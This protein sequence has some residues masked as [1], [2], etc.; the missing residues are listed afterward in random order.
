MQPNPPQHVVES[1]DQATQP[2]PAVRPPALPKLAHA[3]IWLVVLSALLGALVLMCAACSFTLVLLGPDRVLA[4]RDQ[5]LGDTPQKRIEAVSQIVDLVIRGEETWPAPDKGRLT[6]LLMGVDRRPEQ[7]DVP[8]R[9][10]AI[11]LVTIDPI[12]KTAALLSIPRDLYVPLAGLNRVDRINTAYFFGGAQ[13][14]QDTLAWNLGLPVHKH[15]VINFDGFKRAIDALGG[16]DLD[17]PGRIVD[18]TYP[19]EDYGVERLVIEAGPTHMDGELA[20]KY[21]RTRHQDSD[22]GRLQR[23]Q[24]VLLAVRDKA[25]SLGALAQLP[26]LLDAVHG[27][28]ETD[29]SVAEIASIA[30]VWSEIP[31]ERIAVYRIDESMT[32]YW[33][34]PTGASVLIPNRDAIAP[35]VAAFLGQAPP[36][37]AGAP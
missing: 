9:S 26:Q 2:R 27:L 16:I 20:L 15:V 18:E 29:L 31:R 7:D 24:Q 8:T 12:S 10:D 19:T 6:V 14:A 34:T 11:T 4:L 17:V 5:L 32:Q 21:V 37:S 33:T 3:P 13:A 36:A 25:L 28:Y 22:F 23:Q 30:K 35:V 1:G